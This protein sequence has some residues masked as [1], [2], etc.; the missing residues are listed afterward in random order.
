MAE[1]ESAYFRRRAQEEREAAMKSPHGDAR[2]SHQ[3]LANRYEALADIN[4]QRV[5]SFLTPRR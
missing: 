2:R 5:A 3:E 4:A 1:S